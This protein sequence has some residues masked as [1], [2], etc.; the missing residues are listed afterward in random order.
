MRRREFIAG[1]GGAVAWPALAQALPVI[2]LLESSSPE[3]SAEVLA[4]FRKGLAETGYAEGRNV[5]IELRCALREFN[6]LPE[7]AAD[8]V[9]R[10][11][12]VLATGGTP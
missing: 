2:G 3:D 4:A 1:L 9:R 11:V 12:V 8:L 6:R 10:R 7:L 5:T